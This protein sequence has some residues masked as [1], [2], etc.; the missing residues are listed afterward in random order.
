MNDAVELWERPQAKRMILLAGWRQWADAGSVSSG[1][2]EYLVQQTSAR[3]IGE[4]RPD[5][6]YL[7]QIPGTH[8]LVRPVVKFVDG[9]PKSLET[10]HTDIYYTGDDELGVVILLGDEPHLDMERYVTSVLE[11]ARA[12][13]VTRMVSFGGVYGELPYNKARTISA[14]FSLPRMKDE[15]DE[16]AVELSNYQGGAAMG[17]YFCRRAMEQD[18]EYVG[19]YAFVPTYDLSGLTE[20]PNA[21]RIENDFM[22]WHGILQRVNF[23][24]KTSFDL[25]DLERRSK[26]LVEFMDEKVEEFD[27]ASPQLGVRDYLSQLEENFNEVIFNPLG[28]V[29]RDELRRLFDE[30]DDAPDEENDDSSA[31]ESE[32]DED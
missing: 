20:T 29:W 4:I 30:P 19:L 23:M 18:I 5:G 9:M 27:Q 3:Q 10:P 17:S 24:I 6:F 32:S 21:V 2:P 22:A 26:R 13:E 8:D 15:I 28:D 12:L 7:F 16:L 1:L 14:V 11:L 25:S 31:E